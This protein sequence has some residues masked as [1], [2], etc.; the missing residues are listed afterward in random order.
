MT[1]KNFEDAS[2]PETTPESRE[3][4]A[5]GSEANRN[6][7]F[8]PL[9]PYKGVVRRFFQIHRH[10]T[11]LFMGGIIA[12]VASLSRERKKGF[13]SFPSRFIAFLIKPF[14]KRDLRNQPFPIQLRKR[15]ELLGPTYIKLGQI[16]SLREDILPSIITNE[17]KNLLYK[18]PE[19]PF[20]HIRIIIEKNLR[21]SLDTYFISVDEKA[22][23]SASIAQTHRAV[24]KD[25]KEVVL[26]VI[27]PGIKDTIETDIVLLRWLGHFLNVTIPQYQPKRLIQEFCS[28]TIKEVDLE[29]EADNAEIFKANF[30]DNRHIRFP[31]IYR[32]YSTENVLCMEFLDGVKPDSEELREIPAERRK[33]II[34]LGADA[35]I[36]MLYKDGFFHADL[37]PGNLLILPNDEIG[38]IDLGMVGR[39]EESTRRRMLYYFHSLVSG[40]IDGATRNLTALARIGKNGDPY[41]FRRSV[42]DLLRRFY[43][44]S[45]Y[46]DFSLGELIVNSMS[47]GARY[48]VFFPVEMTLMTKALV[49]YEG[50]GKM[51]YPNIDIPSVSRKHAFR[52]FKD[53]FHPAAIINEL[54][55]GTPELVD[56]L[57]RLPR[58]TADT[59]NYLDNTINDRTPTQD[60]IHGL[61][62]SILS[63]ACILGGTLAVVQGGPWP[64]WA[65][66]F[67][68]GGLF[69]L[70]NR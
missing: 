24:T 20:E 32:E 66:L 50:V 23:G 15:L 53:Q 6:F 22:L 30:H 29:N 61:R 44:H 9:A 16:L 12:Y 18:L 46:G 34:D 45:A 26:K 56:A 28:Y 39:F 47:I 14:V 40:D 58:I 4:V 19:V 59:L 60:P 33:Q 38:F 17:L 63:G 10:V 69:F 2:K 8:D 3:R 54:W 62:G 49:T 7:H 5:S 37:H 57:M 21:G 68:L 1:S 43:Q 55:R 11:G 42:A 27:K 51:L 36:R 67:A 52:I 70:I 13:R 65:S 25:G 35:I 41:G 31:E 64:L 48:R